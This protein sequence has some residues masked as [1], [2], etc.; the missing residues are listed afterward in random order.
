MASLVS[1]L[2]A[3]TSSTAVEQMEEED[4][5]GS[6]SSSSE[7]EGENPDGGDNH[8]GNENEDKNENSGDDNDDDIG[9]G[10]F[11]DPYPVGQS[12]G[13]DKNSKGSNP[14][15]KETGARPKT[16]LESIQEELT[17]EDETTV[18]DKS[19]AKV[20]GEKTKAKKT[21]AYMFSGP[22]G[23]WPTRPRATGARLR[24]G[25]VSLGTA[26]SCMFSVMS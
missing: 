10:A 20:G 7:G 17:K 13:T 2:V 24:G 23:P 6:H 25:K 4:N 8:P 5:E 11:D 15:P 12:G 19:N 9:F 22:R 14:T 16:T 3:L 21:K 18:T 26:T 1:A